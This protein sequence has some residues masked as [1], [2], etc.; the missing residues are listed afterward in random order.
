M[1][2]MRM[3]MRRMIMR[4][5]LKINHCIITVVITFITMLSIMPFTDFCVVT[6]F[7]YIQQYIPLDAGQ[8]KPCIIQINDENIPDT[9]QIIISSQ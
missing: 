7:N 8:D 6:I 9:I 2:T 3:T 1:F 5:N 4:K